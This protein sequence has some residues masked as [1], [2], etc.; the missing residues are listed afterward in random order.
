MFVTKMGPPEPNVCVFA[1]LLVKAAQD[2]DRSRIS[3]I[4]SIAEV[5]RS[6][7][8]TVERPRDLAQYIEH[9]A[10]KPD[11]TRRTVVTL[12]EEVKRFGFR[13]VCVNPVYVAGAKQQL[14]GSGRAVITVV[15]F[16]LGANLSKTKAAETRAVIENGADEVDMVIS[17]GALKAGEY[18][19]VFTDI[20]AV[21]EAAGRIPV[22]VILETFLLDEYQKVLGCLLA[23]RA[24]AAFVK[25]S[26]GFVGGGATVEDV[27]LMRRVTGERVKIKAAGSIKDFQTARAMVMAGADRLGCSASVAIVTES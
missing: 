11:A 22:K 21:V 9:T 1:E 2:L 5:Q 16:P 13:G 27:V 24:G 7:L 26:T 8:A 18:E 4:Q 17:I 19:A 14:A 23:E 3:T 25:T 20:R 10:L 6:R 15:G 12:C